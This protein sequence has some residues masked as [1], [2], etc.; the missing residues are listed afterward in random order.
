[1]KQSETQSRRTCKLLPLTR[2]QKILRDV[3][4]RQ[5][6]AI[7]SRKPPVPLTVHVHAAKASLSA[8]IWLPLIA[9]SGLSVKEIKC[10]IFATNR[11]GK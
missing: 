2:R 3:Y 4:K 5:A 7:A 11:F 1:M 6:V 8:R 10:K 9:A